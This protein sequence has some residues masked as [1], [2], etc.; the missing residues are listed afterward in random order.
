MSKLKGRGATH[1]FQMTISQIGEVNKNT[2]VFPVSTF[3]DMINATRR[4]Q[5]NKQIAHVQKL[6]NYQQFA[7]FNISPDIDA[8]GVYNGLHGWHRHF[9][10]QY[11]MSGT[12]NVYY[13]SIK[14]VHDN[15]EDYPIARN[16]G[17][18]NDV[19]WVPAKVVN[20]ARRERDKCLVKYYLVKNATLF[21]RYY[22]IFIRFKKKHV[23]WNTFCHD[24]YF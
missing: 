21:G 16:C 1:P 3:A 14:N 17:N 20:L 7:E 19:V 23:N 8:M 15:T 24:F 18:P 2:A 5:V 11:L 10:R 12:I 6:S 22:R 13:N 9:Y 4:N